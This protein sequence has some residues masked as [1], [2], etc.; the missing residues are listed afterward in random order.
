MMDIVFFVFGYLCAG[1]L[2]VRIW[3][4]IMGFKSPAEMAAMVFFAWPVCG[5]VGA[6]A[7]VIWIIDPELLEREIMHCSPPPWP[8]PLAPTPDDDKG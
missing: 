3:D 4:R 7:L 8:S 6:V 1:A 2:A 5:L